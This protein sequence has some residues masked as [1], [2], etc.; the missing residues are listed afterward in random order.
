MLHD[1]APRHRRRPG[2]YHQ[3]RNQPPERKE[4]KRNERSVPREQD[5]DTR[6]DPDISDVDTELGQ[7]RNGSR[8]NDRILENDPII[9]V[10]NIF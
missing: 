9:D 3:R 1:L 2:I 5:F 4:K 7:A 8:T 10:S 6:L